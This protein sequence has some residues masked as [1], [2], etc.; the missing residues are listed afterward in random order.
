MRNTITPFHGFNLLII[1]PILVHHIN[2]HF[3][4][5]HFLYALL[6]YHYPIVFH[7]PSQF[8]LS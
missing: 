3:Y 4:I 1:M 2:L 7:G 8:S 6:F 5:K